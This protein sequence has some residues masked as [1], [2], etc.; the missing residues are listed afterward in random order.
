M[1]EV[2]IVCNAKD[3]PVAVYTDEAAAASHAGSLR[4]GSVAVLPL[5]E[6]APDIAPTDAG[7]S[8]I[9]PTR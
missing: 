5:L 1:R 7:P 2:F 9:A 4:H 3:Q 6:P 8:T